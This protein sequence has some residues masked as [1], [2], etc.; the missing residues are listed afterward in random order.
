MSEAP[1]QPVFDLLV[2]G[3]PGSGKPGRLLA[4]SNHSEMP[5]RKMNR[6]SICRLAAAVLALAV[7]AGCNQKQTPEDLKEKTAK[8]TAELKRD[9]RAVAAGVRE[10]WNRDHTVDLNTASK[11][12][13]LA[14]PG[15]T[16]AEA[17]RLIA[18]RPYREPG[19]LVTRRIVPK[20]EYDKIADRI[21]TKK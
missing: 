2:F 3:S 18:G 13:L 6:L 15:L 16:P 11:D 14:L 12:E 9:A 20:A 8:A 21:T 19:E 10:G 17:D 1:P 5:T 4:S 7:I